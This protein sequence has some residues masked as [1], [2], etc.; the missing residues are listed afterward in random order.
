M[1]EER[2][3]YLYKHWLTILWAA[4][5]LASLF[6][7]IHT[8]IKAIP[9]L[10]IMLI[11]GMGLTMLLILEWSVYSP[12]RK[13]ALY[14]ALSGAS[15]WF[16]SAMLIIHG[17]D[18]R[19]WHSVNTVCLLL[20]TLTVGFWLAG[21][22]E[23]SGHLLP[24]C[25]LGTLV[26]IWSVFH[27]ISK[28][29]GEQV[30]QHQQKI[31]ETGVWSP[32]PMVELLIMHWPYPGANM[33]ASMFGVGDL[34]FIAMFMGASRRFNLPIWQTFF[35]MILGLGLATGTAIYLQKPIPALPFL[36]ILFLAWYFS[37]FSLTYKEWRITIIISLIVLAVIIIN[38][39]SEAL[40]G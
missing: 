30:M 6:I 25:I 39:I 10:I 12:K 31:A 11:V 2:K 8:S 37:K 18:W 1:T 7:S 40:Q 36:C 19:I 35:L 4:G 38:F 24:I 22:I 29:V 27:G 9:G 34:A 14:L 5:F 26:D 23:K 3:I 16:A 21:E 15:W 33:M 20:V 28:N 13:M 17:Y 32:P